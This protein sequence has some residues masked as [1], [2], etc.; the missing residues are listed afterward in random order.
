MLCGYLVEL[1]L[2]SVGPGYGPTTFKF[3]SFSQMLVPD[4]IL[5]LIYT[6]CSIRTCCLQALF[7]S[8]LF[9]PCSNVWSNIINYFW[10][11]S[12]CL[13]G[14][15]IHGLFFS[16]CQFLLL[17]LATS[18]PHL[19]L[20]PHSIVVPD[21]E[22][23]LQFSDQLSIDIYINPFKLIPHCGSTS[24]ASAGLPPPRLQ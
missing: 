21:S 12:S 2:V 9:Y 17:C 22:P 18:S 15:L 23:D 16:A 6:S 7:A 1:P 4:L 11:F 10:I 5:R 13:I 24:S 8:L 19:N 20:H 3:L 14:L